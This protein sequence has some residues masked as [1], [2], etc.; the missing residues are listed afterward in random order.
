MPSPAI[1]S[2]RVSPDE[3]ALLQ[4]AAKQAKTN[5]SD[6]IRRKAIEAAEIEML[7][8]REVLIPVEEWEAFEKWI[9][10]PPQDSPKMRR[11]AET[12]P[13]WAD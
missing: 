9:A 13:I 7:E 2:V 4:S 5:V 12:K 8:R 3:R 6:F 11:L 10:S 1:L